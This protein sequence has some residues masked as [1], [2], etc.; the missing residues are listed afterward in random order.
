MY[1]RGVGV[2]RDYVTAYMWFHLGEMKGD[3]AAKRNREFVETRMAPEEIIRA[4]KL[5][6]EWMR[7]Y[8]GL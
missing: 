1:M 2:A 8:V 3:R 6:E 5:V 7:R 4:N